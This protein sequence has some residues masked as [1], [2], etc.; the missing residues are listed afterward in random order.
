MKRM[1]ML[2]AAA[3]LGI[4]ASAMADGQFIAGIDISG[5]GD[6]SKAEVDLGGGMKVQVTGIGWD[7]TLNAIDGAW[8][9]DATFYFGAPNQ[10]PV[11][12]LTPGAG[13]NESG[14]MFFSSDGIIKLEDVGIL[15][16]Q[17]D[18]GVLQLEMSTLGWDVTVRDGGVIW[19]QYNIIPAPGALAL[20]GLA[21]LVS[22]RRRA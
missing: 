12:F 6:L 16:I 17:L 14:E 3:T 13:V 22:R 20:V 19:V 2:A 7:M 11:L 5:W 10:D 1:A 8:F 9:S 4:G 21:G 18:G 15:P